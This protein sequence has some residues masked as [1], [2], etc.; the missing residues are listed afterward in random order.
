MH[1]TPPTAVAVRGGLD[2]ATPTDQIP[3]EQAPPGPDPPGA[4]TP[5][6]TEWLTDRCKNITFTNFVS[7][8]NKYIF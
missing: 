6:W 5:L 1:T 2:Q 3:A 7:G 8:G 4:G